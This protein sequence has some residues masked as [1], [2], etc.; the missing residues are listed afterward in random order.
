MCRAACNVKDG[1]LHKEEVQE[2]LRLARLPATDAHVKEVF[3]AACGSSEGDAAITWNDFEK[4]SLR[5]RED[6]SNVFAELDHNQDGVIGIEDIRKALDSL[7]INASDSQIRKLLERADLTSDGHL[8][9]EDFQEFLLLATPA[10]I[11][12][13]F[14]YWAHASAID[15]GETLAAT[16]ELRDAR[17]AAI[18]FV[19]GAVAGG[20]SRTTT[21]PLDRLKLLYQAGRSKGHSIL[22]GLR[23]IYLEGGWMGFWRGNGTNV[24][25]IMPESATRFWAYDRAKAIVSSD[26][27]NV[28]VGER[29]LAGAAAGVCAQTLVYPLE[30]TKTRMALSVKG[31][32]SGILSCVASTV[33]TGGLRGLYRGLLPSTLGIIPYSGVDLAVFWTLRAKWLEAHPST[34]EGPH[35][36]TLLGFGALSSTAG[37]LA[38]YPLQLVRTRLQ[39]SGL[40]GL[41]GKDYPSYPGGISQVFAEIVREEGF[42]GLYRGLGPNMLKAL[43]AAAVSYATFAAV[44]DRMDRILA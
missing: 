28:T 14:D 39:A 32:F 42:L 19:A 37:Q 8:S 6:L 40:P 20:V 2:G 36:V 23:G 38:S 4:F 18:T 7:Q 33:Q 9:L 17:Q 29:F 43:P 30:I 15:I 35:F 13:V 22:S 10:S 16:E 31:E 24:V 25:K 34:A 1:L 3:S 5:R 41:H 27:D 11:Q 44:K 26:P 12:E 21:A